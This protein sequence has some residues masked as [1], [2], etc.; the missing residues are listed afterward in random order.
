MERS[1]CH[2]SILRNKLCMP[3]RVCLQCKQN[4]VVHFTVGD[5]DFIIWFLILLRVVNGAVGHYL[6]YVT[7]RRMVVV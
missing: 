4:W 5:G 2:L 6:V 7:D 3:C 1:F